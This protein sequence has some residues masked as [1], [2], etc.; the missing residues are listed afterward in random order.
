[1]KQRSSALS[2]FDRHRRIDDGSEVLD[3]E[4]LPKYGRVAEQL[5]PTLRPIATDKYEGQASRRNDCR[6]MS[7]MAKSNNEVRASGSASWILPASAT[8]RCPSS[9][10]I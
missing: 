8:T 7:K 1:M 4:W 5:R 10:S 3:Q 9:S 2:S 6:L